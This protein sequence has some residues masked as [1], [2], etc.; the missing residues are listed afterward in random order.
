VR[1]WGWGE[2]ACGFEGDKREKKEAGEAENTGCSKDVEEFVG[3]GLLNNR[4]DVCLV[5]QEGFDRSEEGG[6]VGEA[7]AKD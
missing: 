4:P 2:R 3:G 7:D 1:F 5:N 6:E